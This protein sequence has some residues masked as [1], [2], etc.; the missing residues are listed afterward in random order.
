MGEGDVAIN[1]RDANEQHYELPPE[2]FVPIMGRHM[3]YS[4][5]HY[6]TG[7]ESMDEAEAAMLAKTAERAQ[8]QDG[9]DVLELGCGWGS[10]SLWMAE[11]YPNSRITA[12]SNSSLQRGFI[13]A[14]AKERGL[15]NVQVLTRDMNDFQ[16]EGQYDRVLSVEM[17]EHMRNYRELLRRVA[18]WLKDDGKVFIHVFSHKDMPYYFEVK[19]DDDWMSKLFFTG[20][21]MPSDDLFMHFQEDLTVEEHWTVDGRHYESTSNDW[22]KNMDRNKSDILSI[23]ADHYGQAEAQLWFQR[24]RIFFMACAELWGMHGGKEWVISHYRFKK[25][26]CK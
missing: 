11:H 2:F 26:N 25:G 9:Q 13:E 15:T 1:T 21:I 19:N 7:Q 17:F 12:V 18:S 16:A 8:L 4:C 3:K 5:C 14:R 24:W 23:L 10:L 22:L 6:E 20:G